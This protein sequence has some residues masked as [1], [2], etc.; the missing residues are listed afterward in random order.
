MMWYWGSGM[1][2]WGWTLGFIGMIAFWGLI[3]WAVWYFVTSGTRRP[4]QTPR[5]G[6]AQQILDERLAR[7]EIDSEEYQRL[8]A[9][10]R[11]DEVR[12]GEGRISVGTGGTRS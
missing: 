5:Q 3:I 6:Q 8:R 2:W 10:L 7:G 12:T 9:L 4:D 11:G 1:H